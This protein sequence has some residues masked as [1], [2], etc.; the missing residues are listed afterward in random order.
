LRGQYLPGINMTVAHIARRNVI[1]LSHW[2][3]KWEEL[4]VATPL[5]PQEVNGFYSSFITAN[6]VLVLGQASSNVLPLVSTSLQT[7]SLQVTCG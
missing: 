2:H 3:G 6:T 4:S 7:V 1:N 5:T